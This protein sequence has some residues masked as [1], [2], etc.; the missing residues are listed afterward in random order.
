[1]PALTALEEFVK[2]QN[3]LSVPFPQ[4]S[5]ELPAERRWRG[6]CLGYK[7]ISEGVVGTPAAVEKPKTEKK[8]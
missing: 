3:L 4:P 6:P 7:V 1:M 8:A 2:I 5:P